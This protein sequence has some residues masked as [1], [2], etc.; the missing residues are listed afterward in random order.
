MGALTSGNWTQHRYEC[1]PGSSSQ[2]QN[3]VAGFQRVMLSFVMRSEQRHLGCDGSREEERQSN[4]PGGIT[5]G[6]WQT[7]SSRIT[8]NCSISFIKC[9]H[10]RGDGMGPHLT[11]DKSSTGPHSTRDKASMGPHSTWDKA[12][13]GQS[14]H[15]TTLDMDMLSDIL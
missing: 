2:I 6:T 13:M 7:W 4:L 5:A 12:S 11:R 3:P 9:R 10:N 15:G 8:Q 1:L 14:I